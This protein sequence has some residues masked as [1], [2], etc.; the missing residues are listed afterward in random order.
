[1]KKK[2]KNTN[3]TPLFKAIKRDKYLLLMVMPCVLYF[4]I[5]HYLPMAWNIVAFQKYSIRRGILGSEW[6][7]LQ[8]FKRFFESPYA[9]RVIRNTFVLSFMDLVFGFPVPVIFALLLNEV[10]NKTVK[11]AVQ[12]FS[13]LPHFISVV[14]VV[15]IMK[16]ILNPTD[17]IVNMLIGKL[18]GTPVNFFS[19]ASAFRWLYVISNIWQNFGWDSIIYFAAISGVSP[20]LYEAA[21]VDGAGRWKKMWYVTLPCISPTI[22]VL[23]IMRIG[24]LLSVGF[25][26]IILM[27]NEST[28][29]TADVISTYVYRAGLLNADFSYGTAIGLFNCLVSLCLVLF[30]NY[31]SR[32][33]SDTALF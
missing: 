7:G 1:M 18:G 20:D 5:F 25:E 16:I 31:V 26:K 19:E 28:Y 27:Y 21:I 9:F 13:Y 15:G 12:T 22:I 3:K 29:E 24:W 6:V 14:A 23:L 2:Q 30:A 33:V 17:G 4:L 11:K 10:K 32:K 8:N